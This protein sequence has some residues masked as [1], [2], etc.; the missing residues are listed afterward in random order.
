MKYFFCMI[1]LFSS[2]LVSADTTTQI[3]QEAIEKATPPISQQ[4]TLNL[5]PELGI[6]GLTYR[7]PGIED[8]SQMSLEGKMSASYALIPNWSVGGS[9]SSTLVSITSSSPNAARFVGGDFFA[10]CTPPY[11]WDDWKLSLAVGGIYRTTF[12]VSESYG[13]KNVRG[14]EFFPSVKKIYPD[15][16]SLSTYL[17]Y[18]PFLMN[19]LTSASREL[20]L[21]VAYRLPEKF[22]EGAGF[23]LHLEWFSRKQ[24]FASVTPIQ[25]EASA[26]SMG[27]GYA[28]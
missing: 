24:V 20:A 2:T 17:K 18:S 11:Q 14:L 21:G 8:H 25:I 7:E 6:S 1:S 26:V 23:S 16:R 10:E 13:Y 15:G 19:G 9:F 28:L 4:G 22:E 12:V 5:V 3:T 27:V